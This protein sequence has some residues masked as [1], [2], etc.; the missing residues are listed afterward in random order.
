MQNLNANSIRC[1]V[2]SLDA[3][4]VFLYLKEGIQLLEEIIDNHKY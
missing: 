1:T 4:D 3:Q 2:R